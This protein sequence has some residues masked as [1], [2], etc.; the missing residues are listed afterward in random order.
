MDRGP[1]SQFNASPIYYSLL[2]INV[3][4]G[5]TF[6]TEVIQTAPPRRPGPPSHV[7]STWFSGDEAALVCWEPSE[8][9]LPFLSYT[10]EVLEL[11]SSVITIRNLRVDEVKDNLPNCTVGYSVSCINNV[12]VL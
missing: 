12:L 6:E 1:T 4:L 10:I 2:K 11:K 7:T 5:P 9:G 8:I 3:G